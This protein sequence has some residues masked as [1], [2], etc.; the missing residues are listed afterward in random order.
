L[1]KLSDAADAADEADEQARVRKKLV[2]LGIVVVLAVGIYFLFLS[3]REVSLDALA[4]TSVKGP[5]LEDRV[6]AAS[7]L[8]LVQ[9]G[10]A[11]GHLR[12]VLAETKDPEVQIVAIQYLGAELDGDSLRLFYDALASPELRVRIAAH[13]AAIRYLGAL[14][15]DIAYRPNSPAGELQVAVRKLK[16]DLLKKEELLKS[17]LLK[18]VV[19]P[20]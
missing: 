9:G 8:S 10:K 3:P 18:S 7:T 2:L 4:E 11:R 16:E 19:P 6:R 5:A 14:P 15:P 17:E 12:K 20:P 1:S 13:A